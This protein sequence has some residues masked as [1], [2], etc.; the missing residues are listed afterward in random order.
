M[1]RD[2]DS[3]IEI[4]FCCLYLS[5]FVLTSPLRL[6]TECDSSARDLSLADLKGNIYSIIQNKF[7]STELLFND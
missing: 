4:L 1:T 3:E 2:C 5:V 6:I 7:P